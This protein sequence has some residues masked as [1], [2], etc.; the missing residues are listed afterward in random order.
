LF[1]WCCGDFGE[2]AFHG[3]LSAA[4]ESGVLLEFIGLNERGGECAAGDEE[5]GGGDD[6]E[7]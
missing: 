2:A 1:P 3:A 4:D 5:G 6:D 7:V